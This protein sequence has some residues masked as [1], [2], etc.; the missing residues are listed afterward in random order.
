MLLVAKMLG[1][2]RT[3]EICA[4]PFTTA[5]ARVRAGHGRFCSSECFQTTQRNR[6][7]RDCES[8]GRRFSTAAAIARLG[9]GRFCSRECFALH[10]R[11]RH[12]KDGVKHRLRR[13]AGHP[14]APPSGI[15]AIS[16]LAL[17]DRIG[18]GTHPCHWCSTPVTWIV[19]TGVRDQRALL[20]DHLDHDATNDEPDN[21]VAACNACN[22]HRR[23]TGDTNIRPGDPVV[24]RA[25]G[26]P[27]RAIE[28]S[29]EYCGAAFLAAA[30]Q[31]KSGK[32]RFCSR[33]CARS[34]R[35]EI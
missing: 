24:I 29:C 33:S 21:L 5:P 18:P 9:S 22:A 6:V 20:A 8:C 13:A 2:Q 10:R 11:G 30:S 4:A 34:K 32:G 14:L 35:G 17:Y 26:K 31:V 28:R 12:L 16:R 27:V 25:D 1:V 3:C 15:V 19:G 23:R 7:E